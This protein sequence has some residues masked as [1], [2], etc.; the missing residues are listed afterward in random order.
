MIIIETTLYSHVHYPVVSHRFCHEKI[1]NII[2][3]FEIGHPSQIL[4]D[5]TCQMC[6]HVSFVWDISH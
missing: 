5:I 2:L 4:K 3:A 6:L 1:L